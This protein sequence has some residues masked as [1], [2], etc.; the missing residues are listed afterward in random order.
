MRAFGPH[1]VNTGLCVI[2]CFNPNPNMQDAIFY[3]LWP[4]SKHATS[5]NLKPKSDPGL[6]RLW[7]REDVRL[8]TAQPGCL[9]KSLGQSGRA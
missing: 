3:V 2:A 5:H 4:R 8:P 9:R 6:A 1:K 7:F